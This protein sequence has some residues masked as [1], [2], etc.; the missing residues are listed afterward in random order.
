[1]SQISQTN[2]RRRLSLA[3]ALPLL[4]MSILAVSLI[5]QVNH[6][7]SVMQWVNHTDRVIAQANHTEKL[8]IDMETGLRG[9]L[10]TGNSEF[11]EPYQQASR[12]IAPTFNQL[13]GLVSDN[14]PQVQRLATLQSTYQQWQG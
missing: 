8:L 3:L 4:L 7:T 10:V 14:P 5:G 12:I 2:F 1:M 13:G 11:L 9:Y 6:L